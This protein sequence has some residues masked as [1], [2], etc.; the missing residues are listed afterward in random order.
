MSPEWKSMAAIPERGRFEMPIETMTSRERWLAV[1]SRQKPDR[2]PMGYWATDEATEML[3]R[4][5]NCQSEKALA[6]LFFLPA[7]TIRRDD[8]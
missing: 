7:S 2:I 5:I 6:V 3:I 4:H 1:L 8:R